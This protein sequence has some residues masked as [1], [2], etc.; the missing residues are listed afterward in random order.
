MPIHWSKQSFDNI[1][2]GVNR[3]TKRKLELMR[4]KADLPHA[5]FDL[6]GD[7]FVSVTDLFLAKR[8]DKD[9]DGKLNEEELTTAK[10]ALNSGYKDQFMFGLER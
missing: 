3:M 2:T 7:G 4:K 6:D 1:E 9:G 10:K 8:F 5:S